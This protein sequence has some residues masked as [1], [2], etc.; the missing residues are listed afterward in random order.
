VSRKATD[1]LLG[2]YNFIQQQHKNVISVQS[3]TTLPAQNTSERLALAQAVFKNDNGI[4]TKSFEEVK[5][6]NLSLPFQN[7]GDTFVSEDYSQIKS[8]Y[9]KQTQFSMKN[10]SN[11]IL[12]TNIYIPM[13]IKLTSGFSPNNAV[14]LKNGQTITWNSDSQN[15]KGVVIVIEYDP[16]LNTNQNIVSNYP[17][18]I[19]K[20]IGLEDNGSYTFKE[21]DLSS[22]PVGA[23]V[24]FTIGRAG[25]S[26]FQPANSQETYSLC[27]YSILQGKGIVSN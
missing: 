11:Q 18:Y 24:R 16:D 20:V 1:I 26:L 2:Y 7:D 9:G 10:S 4:A 13:E 8:F 5:I 27:G 23:S 25:F 19:S 14:I 12:S 22:F 3:Y 21:Q 15:T 17:N 6:D